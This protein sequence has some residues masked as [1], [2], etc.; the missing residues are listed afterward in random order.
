MILLFSSAE[1]HNYSHYPQRKAKHPNQLG[2]FTILDIHAIWL[3]RSRT[4]SDFN[5]PQAARISRPR[6]VRT[7]EA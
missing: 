7:G 2:F 1:G 4:E 3:A 6:G 5:W